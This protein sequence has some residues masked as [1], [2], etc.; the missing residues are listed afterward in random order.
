MTVS[1]FF[2]LGRSHPPARVSYFQRHGSKNAPPQ[3]PNPE[4]FFYF[5]L[6]TCARTLPEVASV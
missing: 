5:P 1:L 3:T 2:L 6:S 4:S